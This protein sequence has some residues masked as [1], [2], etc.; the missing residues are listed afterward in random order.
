MNRKDII[1][2]EG[3]KFACIHGGGV[4]KHKFFVGDKTICTGE[5]YI[6]M[7]INIGGKFEI[8]T[9]SIIGSEIY[10]TV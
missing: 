4:P 8:T 3:V 1:T 5:L 10:P 6:V 7:R 9:Q 2:R